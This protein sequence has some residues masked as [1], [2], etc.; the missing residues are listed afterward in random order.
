MEIKRTRRKKEDVI[1]T[2]GSPV[3]GKVTA[4]GVAK[5]P[6]S[7]LYAEYK[8]VIEDGKVVNAEIGE[9]N[10]KSICLESAKISFVREFMDRDI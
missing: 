3:L 9:Q 8:F 4:V 1:E 10:I 2:T 7:G 5:V 6:G